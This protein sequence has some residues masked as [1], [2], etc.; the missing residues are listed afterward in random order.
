MGAMA[1]PSTSSAPKLTQSAGFHQ[2]HA[3]AAIAVRHMARTVGMTAKRSAT[4][5][6]KK[7]PIVKLPQ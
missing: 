4:M 2:M 1:K 5:P 3:A 6:K 7:R